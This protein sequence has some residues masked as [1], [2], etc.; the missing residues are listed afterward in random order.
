MAR[1]PRVPGY[2]ASTIAG[3]R[4]AH[5]IATPALVSSTTAVLGLAAATV[6]ISASWLLSSAFGTQF[7]P[8]DT[9]G[10]N[11]ITTAGCAPTYAPSTVRHLATTIPDTQGSR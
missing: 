5:G 7:D 2:Q 10:G 1:P 11:A 9:G 4:A 6:E 3:T 8:F